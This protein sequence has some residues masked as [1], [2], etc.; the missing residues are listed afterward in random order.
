MA[1]VTVAALLVAALTPLV[2]FGSPTEQAGPVKEVGP[3]P[4]PQVKRFPPKDQ[5]DPEAYRRMRQREKALLAGDQARAQSLDLTGEGKLLVLLVE[6]AG[7]DTTTW[8]PGDIWDPYGIPEIVDAEDRGD[9]GN[10]IT[11]TMEFSYTGP[12]HNEIPRPAEAPSVTGDLWTEDFSHDH[13][14]NMIFGDGNYIEYT[15]QNGEHVVHDL[16][17]VSMRLYYEEQSKGQYTITGDVVG[18]IP[19]PHSEAFYGADLCPGNLSFVPLSGAGSDGWFNNGSA[20]PDN[21]LRVDYGTPQTLIWDAVD[22]I[23]ANIPDFPWE[24]YDQ[25]GD[26]V[27]DHLLVVHAGPG[28]EAGGGPQGEHALWS[29]SLST[30]YCADPGPDGVCDTEDDIRIGPLIIMPEDGGV[31]VF[32]HEYGHQIGADDLYAY[33]FGD[34]SVGPWSMMSDSWGG[35]NPNGTMPMGFDPWHKLGWGWID[36]VILNYN[37]P[38]TEILLGQASVPPEGTE[39]SILIRLPDQVEQL[40]TAHSGEYMW[41]GG[42]ENL[43]DNKVYRAVDLTGY[44]TA[45]L[46]FWTQWDIETGWDFGFVQ[47]STDGGATWTSLE[48]EDTTYDHD[49]NAIWYVV[50]NLPGFTGSSHGW[51]QET[52]DLTP[53]VGQEILLQFRYA[54]DWAVLWTGWWV[55]DITITADGEVIFFDDVEAGPG[56]W[57]TDPV[58]GWTV[59][60]GIFTF[61]HYYLVEWRN[62]AGFDHAL[63]IGRY[64]YTDWGMLVWYINGKYTNNEIFDYLED[65]PSFGPKGHVLVVDAHPTPARDPTSRYAHNARSNVRQRGYGMRDAAFGLRDTQPF[66]V[67][68]SAYGNTGITY[69]GQPAV[70]A[71]H[72]YQSYYPGLEW[73]NIRAAD[74]PRGP[75]YLWTAIERDASV[76]MP[77]R[78]PYGVRPPWYDP[79]PFPGLAQWMYDVGSWWGW[80]YAE[81]GYGKPLEKGYG[82]NVEVEEEAPD[83]SWARVKFYHRDVQVLEI[84]PAVGAA[85]YV[86]SLNRLGNYLG[87]GHLYAGVDT[88]P[89][90]PRTLYGVV[91]FDLRAI[92]PGS[93]VANAEVVFTGQDTRYLDPSAPGTWQLDLMAG[94]DADWSRVRYWDVDNAEI[95]ATI[96]AAQLNP[97]LTNED[98]G[99]GVANTFLFGDDQLSLLEERINTTGAAS[100]RLKGEAGMPRVRHI[101]DWDAMPVLRIWYIEP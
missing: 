79:A 50:D 53:Y 85:G 12:L 99:V 68:S 45:E 71:F 63:A 60:D 46:S 3:R 33:G 91:Q 89:H 98:L 40:A 84:T 82:V 9:C 32:A 11:Q 48:N 21:V 74:D 6:F 80:W 59:S 70:S 52:F 24:D 27:V 2:T 67:H 25:D 81:A 55:D 22:W 39:D 94:L 87:S 31:N 18:W 17:G 90:K 49:P 7:T 47:V 86:D 8:E 95:D 69:A 42:Q 43:S 19:V 34:T 73:A 72:D 38:D 15:A 36:P 66:Q 56:D 78:E 97:V 16:R 62:D 29:R 28:E 83:L 93:Q 1:I 88:R 76:V 58:G 101:M 13:Y 14:W 10:V 4:Q 57:V 92:P 41:Y 100:F 20:D 65:P 23:N 35:G 64:H 61:P 75:F 30:D 37:D 51:V 77:A 96:R 5:P 54:T 44:T 26:G